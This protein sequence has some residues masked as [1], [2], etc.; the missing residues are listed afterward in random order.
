M[1]TAYQVADYL[2]VRPSRI[3]ELV[4]SGDIPAIKIGRRQLRFDPVAI[5]SW[6]DAHATHAEVQAT[7]ER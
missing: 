4:L 6:L 2:N 3:Y 5:Q 7:K 1:W